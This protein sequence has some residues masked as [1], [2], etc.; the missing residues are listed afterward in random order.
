MLAI[1]YGTLNVCQIEYL[2]CVLGTIPILVLTPIVFLEMYSVFPIGLLKSKPGD[3][4]GSDPSE[5]KDC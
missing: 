2:Q 4:T 5:T 3:T 1:I